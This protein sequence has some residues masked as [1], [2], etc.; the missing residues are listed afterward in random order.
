[1]VSVRIL[2]DSHHLKS[3]VL[4]P[5]IARML[6]RYSLK[7]TFWTVPCLL[8]AICFLKTV[9]SLRSLFTHTCENSH[10]ISTLFFIF[11][12]RAPR[13]CLLAVSTG[14]LLYDKIALPPYIFAFIWQLESQMF[15]LVRATYSPLLPTQRCRENCQEVS[16]VGVFE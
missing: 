10:Q 9:F 1:M 8:F 5:T 16:S 4:L 6:S 11:T 13:V 12:H 7:T 3:S 15:I 14:K 2:R